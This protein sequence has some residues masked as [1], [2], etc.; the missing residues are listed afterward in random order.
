M[1]EFDAKDEK[2]ESDGVR[3]GERGEG[4]NAASKECVNKF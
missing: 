4:D 1:N 2:R 3:K